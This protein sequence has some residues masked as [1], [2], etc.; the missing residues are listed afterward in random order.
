MG[1][2]VDREAPFYFLKSPLAIVP[3]GATVPYP[4]GTHDYHHEM[5][6]VV[7]IGAPASASP[8]RPRSRRCSATPPA[9]T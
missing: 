6:L 5:E 2:E 1:A 7:A 3:S 4:P 8:P 9:S